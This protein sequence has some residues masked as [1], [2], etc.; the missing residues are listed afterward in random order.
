ML[1]LGVHEIITALRYVSE[2]AGVRRHFLRNPTFPRRYVLE[3]L[4]CVLVLGVLWSAN[5]RFLPEIAMLSKFN[6]V[7]TNEERVNVALVI[8]R[9]TTPDATVGVFD[10]GAIPYY[11]GRPAIDFLGK[12][13]RRIARL[14]PDLSGA[15]RNPF[16]EGMIYN[17]GHNR[18]DL[19]Y[20]IKELRPT[21][22][23]SFTWGGQNVL[24]WAK[25][26]YVTLVYKGAR[27]NFL[28]GSGDVRWDDIEALRQSGEATLAAPEW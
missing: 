14:P 8:E 4:A 25:S 10:A 12:M 3:V 2:T 22:A 11:A 24:D 19:E 26:E 9:L 17:P 20:S 16:N 13:D 1:V 27:V 6:A 15:T 21:Y 23:R 18:Y 7:R 5:S 28:K